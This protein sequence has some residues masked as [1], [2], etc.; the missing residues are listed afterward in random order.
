VVYLLVGEQ[1]KAWKLAS[2]M[3]RFQGVYAIGGFIQK[4][5]DE[6]FENDECME[7]MGWV[8]GARR[9]R[10]LSHSLPF[11]QAIIRKGQ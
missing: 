5:E 9:G 11:R 6:Q 1:S 7:E 4:M 8:Y 10:L 2:S 3:G